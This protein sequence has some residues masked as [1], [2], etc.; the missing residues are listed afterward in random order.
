MKRIILKR[1]VFKHLWLK[2]LLSSLL[3]LSSC[4]EDFGEKDSPPF[5]QRIK[6][7]NWNLQTFFD[8]I[9][10]GNEYT[11]YKSAKSGWSQNKYEERLDRLVSVI[12]ELDSDII[13]MEEIE[14]ESQLQDISNRLSGT[15]DFSQLYRHGLFARDKNSSIGCALLSRFPI[16]EISVH[17]LEIRS[18]RHQ[19]AMRPVV[20]VSV[21]AKD[22]SLTLFINHWKS[23]SGGEEES[24]IWRE[25]QES[26]LAELMLKAARK[27]NAL[28]AIGDFN[29]DISEFNLQLSARPEDSSYSAKTNVIL[30]GKENIAV[31]SPWILENGS[32][33]IPGSYWY[34]SQWERIDH[35][36]A[37]GPVI[38]RDFCAENLGEW[39]DSEGHPER[40]QVWKGKGYSDHLPI[41]CTVEF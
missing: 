6:I 2:V 17:S 9:F 31:Y 37:A 34:K 3:F 10:D 25:R 26:L 38:I 32:F 23:K 15:F 28:L 8:P 1:H 33:S 22:K 5:S 11:E 12:K 41:T 19:P 14:K 24:E 27:N 39:A 7:M 29:K 30:R 13:V 18:K 35:F 36:F 21:Y 4:A 40:Y 16:G 20:Q